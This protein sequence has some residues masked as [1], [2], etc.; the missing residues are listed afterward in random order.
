MRIGS[1]SADVG[2]MERMASLQKKEPSMTL[3]AGDADD[4][5]SYDDDGAADDDD[6]DDDD[7]DDGWEPMIGHR[8]RLCTV[9]DC[10]QKPL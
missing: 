1:T 7:D 8:Y 6:Y 9:H 2:W 10:V 4:G 5:G 3:E